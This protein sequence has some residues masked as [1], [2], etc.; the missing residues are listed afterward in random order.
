MINKALHILKGFISHI[1]LKLSDF[2]KGDLEPG[3]I[4]PERFNERTQPHN[5]NEGLALLSRNHFDLVNPV[6]PFC[7]SNHVIKQE[8]YE[9]NPILGEFGTQKIYLS[10][11]SVY[12]T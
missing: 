11:N 12:F 9:W 7:E 4:I 6:C 5:I 2:L 1:Q 8:Y 10:R 3:K